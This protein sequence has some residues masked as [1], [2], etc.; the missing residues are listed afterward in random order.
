MEP[1]VMFVRQLFWEAF[2]IN[3]KSYKLRKQESLGFLENVLL[4]EDNRILKAYQSN[5]RAQ[6]KPSVIM[7]R[8]LSHAFPLP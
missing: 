4:L 1:S 8:P 3:I 6:L 7:A 2:K 5:S